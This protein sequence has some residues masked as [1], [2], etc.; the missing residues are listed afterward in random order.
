MR[1]G[2]DLDGLP[3][4]LKSLLA[5]TK[6]GSSK[7]PVRHRWLASD[8]HIVGHRLSCLPVCDEGWIYWR[9]HFFVISGFLIS[10]ILFQNLRTDRFTFKDFYIRRIRRIFPALIAVLVF[11]LA[12]GFIQLTPGEFQRLGKHILGGASFSSNYVLVKE[13]GYFDEISGFKPLLHLWSL[14]I[15]E[16]FYIVWPLVLWFVWSRHR[17]FEHFG[18]L[19]IFIAITSFFIGVYLIGQS[20]TL[21]F[22]SPL[23]RFWELSVGA[24]LAYLSLKGGESH[25]LGASIRNLLSFIGFI[26]IVAGFTV[27]DSHDRFPGAWALIPTLGAALLIGS[28]SQCWLN[29]NLLSQKILVWFGLISFPLYLWHWPLLAYARIVSGGEVG[30]TLLISIILTSILLA[31]LTYR[32]IEQPLRFG[33]SVRLKVTGLCLS[34]ALLAAFG[35]AAAS[36]M[37]LPQSHDIRVLQYYEM[38]G[39]PRPQGERRV[40]KSNFASQGR[41]ENHKILMLGDSHSEQYH[42]TFAQVLARRGEQASSEVL[43]NTAYIR[44]DKMLESIDIF[45]ND[46][47]IAAVILANYWAISYGSDKINYAERCCGHGPGDSIGGTARHEPLPA[48][49][50][51]EIDDVLIKVS[52]SL[53]RAGKRVYF[54]LD[55]PFGEEISPRG[56][57]I[58]SFLKGP[59]VKVRSLSKSEALAR[60][61]PFWS[62][63]ISIAQSTGATIID[64]F[65]YLCSSEI[66]PALSGGVPI[67][68]DYDHISL[69]TATNL[70][71][72]FDFLLE[73]KK[74]TEVRATMP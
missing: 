70:V 13:N 51:K 71:R 35:I 61:E 14:G 55:N 22:Y 54:V 46:K 19:L 7:I 24:L 5:R 66:C 27:I 25:P 39:Y 44:V 30:N 63:I 74:F 41:N 62:R 1:Q 68:K 49:K 48:E 10:T 52:S 40:P 56:M 6:L 73:P 15:E 33:F 3:A 2:A 67:Y 11:C 34:M 20:P 16:Q 59:E 31:W 8:R 37:L 32:L 42:N 28:G 26:L 21:A 43:Y 60:T 4:V 45:I 53:N 58:R 57:V 47:S 64:P 65:E 38:G 29:R 36:K 12:Y 72:Y 23:S 9:R 50:M 17:K 69:Y 18:W